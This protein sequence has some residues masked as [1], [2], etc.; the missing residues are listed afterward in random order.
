MRLITIQPIHSAGFYNGEILFINRK[1]NAE[2]IINLDQLVSIDKRSDYGYNIHTTN[3]S[4][5]ISNE[6][7]ERVMKELN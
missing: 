7:Y 3:Q 5:W 2:A 6:D 4:Y 1:Q